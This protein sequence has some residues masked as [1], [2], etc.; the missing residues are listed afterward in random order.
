MIKTEKNGNVTLIAICRPEVRNCVN[1]DTAN[2]LSK[3][4]EAFENDAEAAVG[5]LYGIGGNFCA[6]YDL[7]ELSH[8]K[9]SVSSILL[10]S[11]GAMVRFG[12]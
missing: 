6:G 12:I 10:R 1:S 9:G 11:E 7:K 3:A 2:Q 8:N 4:I 5:V